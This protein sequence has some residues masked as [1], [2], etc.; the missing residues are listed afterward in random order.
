MDVAG[1]VQ[2]ACIARSLAHAQMAARDA[3]PRVI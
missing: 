3:V 1:A 2:G